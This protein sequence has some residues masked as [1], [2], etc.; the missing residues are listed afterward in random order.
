[1]P[2]ISSIILFLVFSMSSIDMSPLFLFYNT[3][4]EHLFFIINN[5]FY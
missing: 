5:L 3:I 4:I 1:M 2:F